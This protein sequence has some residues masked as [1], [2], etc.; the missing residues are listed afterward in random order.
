MGQSWSRWSETEQGGQ[1][2]GSRGEASGARMGTCC[3]CI[4]LGQ[5][6]KCLAEHELVLL[7]LEAAGQ[8]R[9]ETIEEEKDRE[10]NIE[11][12]KDR[13]VN[14]EEEKDREVNIEEEKDREVN[15]EEEK[16]R[17][18][19]IEEEKDREVNIEEE[20]DR[21]VNIEED[22]EVTIEEE[23]D[24]EVNIEEEKDREVNIEEEKYREETIEKD[25]EV[26][27]EE[28]KDR[29][30]TI[31]EEKD[32]EVNIE[33]EKD[34]EETIEEE[35]DREETIEEEKDREVNMEEDR[36]ETIEEEGA[37]HNQK[38][39]SFR[40]PVTGQISPENTE[41][42]LHDKTESRGMSKPPPP[43][44]QRPPSMVSQTSKAVTSS[45]VDA[46]SGSKPQGS[47]SSGKVH[48][49]GKRDQAIKRN[50]NI[51]VVVRGWLYKQDSSGIRLWKRKWFVLSDY[52][53]FYYKDSREETV[54]GSIPLPSYVIAPVEP[55][56]H[57][58]RKYAFKA[59]HTGMRSY[60]YNKNSVIGS[61]AE[62]GGMRTYFF[63]ADTQEDMNGWI[64]AM[65]QAA[66][67]QSQGIKRE[68]VT[69]RPEMSVQQ[70]VP[71]TNH[72]NN[73]NTRKSPSQ[74][75][76]GSL[77]RP[78][79][80]EPPE[81]EIR[82]SQGD[83]ERYVLEAPRKLSHPATEVEV[84]VDRLSPD[85]LPGPSHPRNGQAHTFLAALPPEQNGNVV[86]KRGFVPRT[87]TEKQVQRKTALA[88]VEHWVK[89]Q[90]G[91]PK[92][93]TPTTE[94]AL[95]LPRRTP[96]Q[97]PKAVVVEA[98]QT[99]PKTPRLPSGGSSP[100]APRN[101]PSDY[102]YAHDRLSH[103]RMSTDERMATKEGM[104]WQLYEW[105]QRQQFRHGSPTAPI[106]T[107][108][109]FLDTASFRVIVE[110]PRSI[111]VPP[112][113]CEVPP[114]VPTFKPL[115][116]HRPH[117]PSDRVTVR[118]LDEVPPG[119]SPTG[120]SSPRR[121]FSQ[122]SKTSQ[123]E[124]RSMPAMGYITHTVSAPSLH[125]KT[126]E[127]L[128]LLLIQLRSH[129]AK[130]AGVH[131]DALH[132][133]HHNGLLGPSLQAD[134]TYMQLKKDL[135]YLDLKVT[136]RE[137]LKDR[138]SKPVKIAES[139]V[140]V[141]L[142]RLCEQDKILQELETTIRT[143]K[144]DKDKLESVLDV[145]HQQMEQYRDQPAHQEK[146]SYQQRLLQEDVVHIRAEISQV[147]TEMEN[148]WN[149]YSSLER[150]VGWLRTALEGQ[151]N[152]SGLSQ[153]EKSQIKRELWRVEDVIAGLSSSKA[154]YLITISS[155]TNPERKLV[156]SVSPSSMPSLS[157]SPSLGEMRLSQQHSPH[158]SPTTPTS[159]QHTTAALPMSVP[160][161]ADE[162]APPRPPLPQLYSPEDHAPAVPPPP[163]ETSVIRH[164][165]VRGLKRQ[166][167]ERKRD[168][169]IGQY[170]NEDNKVE[171]RTFLSEPELLGVGGSGH[172][173][174]GALGHDGGYQTLPSRGPAGSSSRLN[175]STNI[176]SYVTLRRGASAASGLKERPKSALE[177][178]YS[179]DVLQQQSRG[180]MSA[181]EQLQRLKRHQK[182]LVRQRKRTLS[183]G[184]RQASSSSQQ[185]P[186]SADLGSWRRE[187]EFDLQL[188]ER[189]VQGEEARGVVQGEECPAE[190]SDR[191]RSQSDEW[192]TLR[193]TATSTLTQ[194]AD[195]ETLDYD[196][197]LS[198]E[199]AKPQKVLIPERYIDTEPEEP[200]SPQEV[201]ARHRNMERIKNILAKSSVQ[202]LAG[203][204]VAVDKPEVLG[205]DSALLK[206]ERIITMS[207]ALAS[208]ASLKSKQVAVVPLHSNISTIPPPPPPLPPLLPPVS[209]APP[210]PPPLS[211]GFH[212]SFV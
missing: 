41:Y 54:L 198:R 107:G 124:R 162:G 47:R 65:N 109:D 175:Q 171:L 158:L 71:Q 46:T 17:E 144:E 39:T 202:I 22:R 59:S 211:N 95:P 138:P 135:D 156:P 29:E 166:S 199:L 96:P 137:T 20:K 170:T 209:Q 99:L 44:S 172:M 64:R 77:Q 155:V 208:E 85:T 161:W 13:E 38:S 106:Y 193:S 48:S 26:T 178:L 127:E 67:M 169:E 93:N 139:D 182:A 176:S 14:I 60:I 79:R 81:G 5:E 205:L 119:E 174:M 11:E 108:P 32:R 147:S 50:P 113:P 42:M 45:T 183:Q 31:E 151:M 140:D 27:I 100:S 130:M 133:L 114:S 18:V 168:R 25:R 164:T 9:E 98:Y 24:R 91:D 92:S 112:S 189:A 4:P 37:S 180:R 35:K 75:R 197:D 43:A 159:T 87:A 52:C 28:E 53:L 196:L 83:E 188:L 210:P 125:G 84:E 21:E 163:R 186:L 187:Q 134:D 145:S 154:N 192:L 73:N 55:D 23:K 10:V 173:R 2:Q 136:G 126:P 66:L 78:E 49:F 94:Y 129:Q 115:S 74:S 56:D 63:S 16:D 206:Q 51:P 116:P 86:Y 15:I 117:T 118:P 102:K 103:F 57:I 165:S 105:Q 30:V 167:D 195:L 90:K 36:E 123:L 152:R 8:D 191:P 141:K 146:I 68:A 58:S 150:D 149:E 7:E 132:H 3:S 40:H 82:L 34:R 69:E 80:E 185:R 6:A 111:S 179:G 104:V 110:L 142:S 143:L 203:P 190:H 200:L 157:A 204:Y 70:A 101:L 61:Q 76:S 72:V 153:K 128:T 201:E 88:Q 1:Q 33:Q 212:F 97:Q 181:E 148:A 177:R 131:G 160:K 194:E 62:H 122:L 12:E 184:E 121:V 207:Y 89:V 19:N 120:S